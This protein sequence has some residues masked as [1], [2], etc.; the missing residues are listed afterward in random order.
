MKHDL[1]FK[2]YT[3]L[4]FIFETHVEDKEDYTTITKEESSNK[5]IKEVLAG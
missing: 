1:H 5:D 2:L 4:S 3:N